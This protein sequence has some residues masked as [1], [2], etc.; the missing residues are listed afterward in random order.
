MKLV[1]LSILL[2]TSICRAQNSIEECP[3]GNFTKD[4]GDIRGSG[5]AEWCWA[6]TAADLIGYA[7]GVKPPSRISALDVAISNL[8]ISPLGIEKTI[9]SLNTVGMNSSRIP[10]YQ[11]QIAS[12]QDLLKTFP[13]HKVI[14]L[15]STA[16]L[17]YQSRKG[18]CLEHQ[19]KIDSSSSNS[20]IAQYIQS[21]SVKVRPRFLEDCKNTSLNP[22]KDLQSFNFELNKRILAQIEDEIDE[23]CRPRTSMKPMLPSTVDLSADPMKRTATD[24]IKLGLN[25]GLPIAI[26]FDSNLLLGGSYSKTANHVGI[27]TEARFNSKTNRCEYRL[28][29]S[30]GSDCNIYRKEIRNACDNGYIWLSPDEINN[31]TA[32]IMAVDKPQ[33]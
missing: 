20:Y 17:S 19:L 22:I 16:L 5:G 23:Q 6:N 18:Y 27:I 26:G 8:T 32:M 28:R 1:F 30:N 15:P 3:K 14:G 25:N 12:S 7:Q 2:L 11:G 10:W 24:F 29:D 4:F 31:S 9:N 13:L 21:V 33:E